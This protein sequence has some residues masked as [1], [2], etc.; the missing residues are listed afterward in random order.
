[1]NALPFSATARGTVQFVQ[2]RL[3]ALPRAAAAAAP[4][5]QRPRNCRLLLQRRKPHRRRPGT[6]PSDSG[7]SVLSPM[8]HVGCSRPQNMASSIHAVEV[9][10]LDAAMP[11][12]HESKEQARLDRSKQLTVGI[13]G[14]GTF[15]QFL[16]RRLVKSGHKVRVA[17]CQRLHRWHTATQ[18]VSSL[19]STARCSASYAQQLHMWMLSGAGNI[20]GRLLSGSIWHWRDLLARP[21][22]L[23][24]VASR[25]GRAGVLHHLHRSSAAQVLPNSI[26]IY[27]FRHGDR[28][29]H[30][31]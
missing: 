3:V 6:G 15:G 18:K 13:V 30:F 25:C 5:L 31:C 7:V 24:R 29:F 10:S 21:Q 22:R 19:L 1:M 12:D 2:A 11:F 26:T 27:G 20:T 14:F 9:R 8:A 4:Q 23:L 28:K 17:N 16:A